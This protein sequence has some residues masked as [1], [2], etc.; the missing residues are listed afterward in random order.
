MIPVVLGPIIFGFI[1]GL[2]IGSQIKQTSNRAIRLTS[3]SIVVI[4]ISAIVM[5]WKIGQ[6]PFYNDFPINT[7]FLFGFIGVLVGNLICGR[8]K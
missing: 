4:V 5:A 2:I 7:A 1:F 6:F 3:A 8:G